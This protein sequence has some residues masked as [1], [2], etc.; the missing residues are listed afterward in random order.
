[1]Y[2]K[3]RLELKLKDMNSRESGQLNFLRLV[4]NWIIG[5]KN[6]VRAW[7]DKRKIEIHQLILKIQINADGFIGL[8]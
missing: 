7:K 4:T 6:R 1:M 8:K 3:L 5:E 2:Y